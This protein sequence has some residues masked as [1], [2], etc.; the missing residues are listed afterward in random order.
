MFLSYICI[1]GIV[2]V[3][4]MPNT[5]V[6]VRTSVHI[7]NSLK[8]RLTIESNSDILR[9]F[10]FIPQPSGKCCVFE[11][12]HLENVLTVETTLWVKGRSGKEICT[13]ISM[14]QPPPRLF[15]FSGLKIKKSSSPTQTIFE[16][17]IPKSFS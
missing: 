7:H 2:V 1:R 17:F 5:S 3:R 10:S 4:Q 14:L 16:A 9:G 12:D 11:F 8:P 6:P 13:R 15:V